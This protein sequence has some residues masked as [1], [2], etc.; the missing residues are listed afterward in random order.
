MKSTSHAVNVSSEELFNEAPQKT[1]KSRS[2]VVSTGSALPSKKITNADLETMLDTTDEWIKSRVGIECRYVCDTHE[3]SVTLARDASRKAIETAG[4]DASEID[5]VL[6]ATVTPDKP[7]PSAAAL[8]VRELGIP[9]ALAFDIKAACSGF[10]F[11]LATADSLLHSLNL[12]KALIVGAES[13]SRIT[14]WTDRNTAVLFGDGAGACVLERDDKAS[15]SCILASYLKTSGEGADL[16]QQ[17]SSNHFPPVHAP[18]TKQE[19]TLDAEQSDQPSSYIQMRGREVFKGGVEFMTRSI[20]EVFKQTGMSASDISLFIPHQSNARMIQSVCQN[21]GL[22]DKSKVALNIH[23]TG[24]T[25]AASIPIALDQHNRS[26]KIERG[27]NLL[28][29]AVGSGMTFGS[30]LI[31]W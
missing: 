4:I 30:L 26:G 5:I 24:N 12:N 25:S 29:T 15:E 28:L 18:A 11:A 22:T 20:L 17:N 21:I 7:L 23:E 14:D 2:R 1:P 13:L 16:I 10:I 6:F 9:N 31:Q 3:S 19:A 8:L 27:D